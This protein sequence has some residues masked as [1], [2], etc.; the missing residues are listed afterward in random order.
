VTNYPGDGP[1]CTPRAYSAGEGFIDPGV[2][3]VHMLRNETNDIA[4][5]TIAVQLLP[6]DAGRRI[7]ADAPSGCPS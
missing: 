4:A 5:E 2:G 3:H 6:K 1:S 7:L